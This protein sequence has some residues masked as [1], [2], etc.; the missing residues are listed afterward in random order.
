M[1]SCDGTL[2]RSSWSDSRRGALR[3]LR[4]YSS[5][6]MNLESLLFTQGFGS[7]RQCRALIVDARVSIGGTVCT[8]ADAEFPVTD[9][10]FRYSVD[11]V[12]WH[13]LNPLILWP[14]GNRVGIDL[15]I[16]LVG[17]HGDD[18]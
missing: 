6:A 2:K 10:A 17:K 16:S 11:G 14:E 15:S 9:D 3:F 13:G 12:V 8:D 1:N 7:R 4:C 5:L 18:A